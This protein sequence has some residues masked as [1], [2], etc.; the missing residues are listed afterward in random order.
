[1]ASHFISAVEALEASP[2]HGL[3][4][5]RRIAKL[6]DAAVVRIRDV[7]I[8][9][10]VGGDAEG[11][12]ELPVVAAARSPLSEVGAGSSELLDAVVV[13]VCDVNVATGV[14][15]Y[16]LGRIELSVAGAEGA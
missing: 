1:M 6:L 4:V 16:A 10:S 9:G 5:R 15:R 7:D 3:R 2:G 13:G 8:S 11:S 14:G 12:V